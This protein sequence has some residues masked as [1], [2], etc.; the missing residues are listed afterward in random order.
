MFYGFG[1]TKFF[2]NKQS[3][4]KALS[5]K[6][7]AECTPASSLLEEEEEKRNNLEVD[8]EELDNVQLQYNHVQLFVDRFKRLILN[9][10]TQITCTNAGA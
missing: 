4:K 8:E 10:F 6:K 1:L 7:A 9:C 3:P 5:P 2:S